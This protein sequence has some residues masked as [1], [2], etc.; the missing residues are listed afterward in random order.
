MEANQSERVVSAF[1]DSQVARLTGLSVQQLRHWDRTG[2]FAPSLAYEERRSPYS[3]IYSFNDLAALKVLKKLRVDLG[4][5]LQHL[6]EVKEKLS[7]LGENGWLKTTLFVLNKKV[8][9]HDIELEEY[10]E[11][12][13]GQ[14]VM[15][16]PLRIV[17]SEMKQAVHKLWE[18]EPETIGQISKNRKISHNSNVVAGTRIPVRA[19]QQFWETGYS[20]EEILDQYPTIT[21]EDILSAIQFDEVA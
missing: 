18:R 17:L 12:V 7:H 8:V 5:S 14:L 2:F 15:E 13:S 4:C 20:V 16:I 21:K 9:F 1:T 19:I 10:R 3:R 11:P 6:R